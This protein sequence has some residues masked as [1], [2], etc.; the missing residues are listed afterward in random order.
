ERDRRERQCERLVALGPEAHRGER[1]ER[2]QHSRRRA[3]GA[4]AQDDEDAE[5]RRS[6]PGQLLEEG[7][8]PRDEVVEERREAVEDVE[9]DARVRRVAVRAEPVLEVV[10]IAAER[11]PDE[12]RRPD[13]LVIPAEERDEQR[14]DDPCDEPEA[15]APPGSRQGR[16]GCDALDGDRHVYSRSPAIA[17]RTPSRSTTP[18]TVPFSTAQHG[19]SL[20]AITGTAS[21]TVVDTS[22]L[23][24]S[25]S[26]ASGSRMIHRSVRTWLFGMSRTKLRT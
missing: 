3:H 21:R 1:H 9:D 15:A 19:R 4:E 14:D 24:P 7:R 8:Q 16:G 6:G 17:R 12:R 13:E 10:E 11:I 2:G 23:G 18:R 5:R 20:A 25:S 26:P 22:S